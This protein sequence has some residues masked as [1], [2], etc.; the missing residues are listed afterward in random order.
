MKLKELK[1]HMEVLHQIGNSLEFIYN[2]DDFSEE[3]PAFYV[4][5][6]KRLDKMIAKEEEKAGIKGG[7]Y[8]DDEF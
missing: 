3:Y 8:D 2:D 6:K 4:I 1:T 5:S 7:H